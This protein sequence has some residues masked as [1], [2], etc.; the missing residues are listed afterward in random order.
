[1]SNKILKYYYR[2]YL[3]KKSKEIRN[4]YKESKKCSGGIDILR[5]SV[6]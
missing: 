4:K 1:M 5:D 6:L 3:K 2:K